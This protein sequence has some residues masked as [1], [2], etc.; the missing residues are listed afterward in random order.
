MAAVADCLENR[1]VRRRHRAVEEQGGLLP[2][3]VGGDRNQLPGLA[4]RYPRSGEADNRAERVESGTGSSRTLH[5]PHYIALH[6]R[7]LC[8]IPVTLAGRQGCTSPSLQALAVGT[9]IR[10]GNCMYQAIHHA[11]HCEDAPDN[12]KAAGH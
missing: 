7:R 4:V 2:E 6:R 9:R 3:A 10:T 8:A 5:G 1:R 12:C 11:T